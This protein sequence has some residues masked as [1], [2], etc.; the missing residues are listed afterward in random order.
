MI[1]FRFSYL[2]EYSNIRSKAVLRSSKVVW[3]RSPSPSPYAHEIFGR[4][5]YI[6]K[7]AAF[8][9]LFTNLWPFFNFHVQDY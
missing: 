4:L 3:V 9:F 6:L 7:M 8:F 1:H 5:T 2:A